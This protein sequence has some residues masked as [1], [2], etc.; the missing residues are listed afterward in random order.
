MSGLRGAL[1]AEL[2]KARR[3]IVPGLTAAGLALLPLVGGLFMIILADPERARRLG[4]IGQKAMLTGGAGD[5]PT[6]LGFLAQGTTVG[7]VFVFGVVAAWVFGREFS[8]R[9][10]RTL[11]ANPTRRTAVVAAKLLLVLGWCMVLS[12]GVL[13]FG[14]V[15]GAALRLPGG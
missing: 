4:L 1:A 11:L 13:A 10:L 8:D 6:Y 5:W 9:T 12:L 14:F 15:V 3:S 7:G 2:L